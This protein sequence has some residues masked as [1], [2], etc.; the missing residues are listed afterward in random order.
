MDVRYYVR[1]EDG[2]VP[3]WIVRVTAGGD[4]SLWNVRDAAWVPAPNPSAT[5]A[6]VEPGADPDYRTVPAVDLPAIIA[7]L[8]ES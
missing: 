2:D 3:L 1:D 4:V 7:R 5:L 6:L 8:G